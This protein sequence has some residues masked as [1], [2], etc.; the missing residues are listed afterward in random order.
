[1]ATLQQLERRVRSGEE[2]RSVV[3]TMKGLAAVAIHEF[4]AAVRALHEYTTTIEQGMQILFKNRIDAIPEAVEHSGPVAT[5]VIGTDQGLCGSVNRDIAR[6]AREWLEEHDIAADRRLVVV[7]GHR[8]ARALRQEGLFPTESASLPSSVETIGGLVDD[9][10][11][12]IE[13]WRSR[14]VRRV[15]VVFQH[16]IRRTQHAP[17]VF[18]IVPPDTNRLR[19][20]AARPWPTRMLP[21]S[22]HSFQELLAGLLRQDLFIALYRA[23]AEAKAAEHG[24]RLAAMHAAEQN[25]EERLEHLRNEYHQLRQAEITEQLLDVVS[26]FEALADT[27]RNR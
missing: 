9:L 1:M 13:R 6:T 16:P 22:P 11:A 25:I 7:V 17:R 20:I 26:G 12:R 21:A 23:V 2:L 24:A 5:I 10:V 19:G 8:A 14:K 4:E 27:N 18:Q 15:L 3:G